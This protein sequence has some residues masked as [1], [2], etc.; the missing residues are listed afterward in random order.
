M[1]PL[2][3]RAFS[4]MFSGQPPLGV[5]RWLSAATGFYPIW[6]QSR[7]EE[8]CYPAFPMQDPE[9]SRIGLPLMK[10]KMIQI[11]YRTNY[12]A[13]KLGNRSEGQV[14]VKCPLLELG[15]GGGI[16]WGEPPRAQ[17]LR[18]EQS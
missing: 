14:E 3:M 12:C 5:T 13:V 16:G 15:S 18:M 6:F 11:R 2:E 8:T 4:M 17:R 1:L 9:L 7:K 10:P